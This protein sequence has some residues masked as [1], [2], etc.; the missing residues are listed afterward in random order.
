MAFAVST[1]HNSELAYKN[2]CSSKCKG[3]KF[4]RYSGSI[5]G[6]CRIIENVVAWNVKLS[7]KLISNFSQLNNLYCKSKN[8][9]T[10][11][12]SVCLCRSALIGLCV[13]ALKACSSV[14]SCDVLWWGLDDSVHKE[15]SITWTSHENCQP[16]VSHVR[17][18]K[19][20]SMTSQSLNTSAKR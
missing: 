9:T 11:P 12:L 6:N 7:N 20:C 4:S 10:L 1:D 5:F 16:P 3:D 2:N 18:R 19:N 14:M 17:S 8:I 15:R 13:A